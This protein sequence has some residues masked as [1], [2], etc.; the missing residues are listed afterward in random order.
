MAGNNTIAIAVRNTTAGPAG[1]IGRVHVVAAGG[2]ADLVTDG[3]W[4]A[5]QTAPAGWEQ[6]AFSDAGWPSSTDLGAYGVAPWATSVAAAPDPGTAASPLTVAAATVERRTNP[7][8]VDAAKPRFGWQLASAQLQQRQGAYQLTVGTTAGAA[9]VWDSGRV[10]SQQSVD[11]VYNGPGA[12]LACAATSG[13]YGSGTAQAAPGAWSAGQTFETALRNPA[14]EWVADFIGRRPTTDLSGASWIWYP[15]GDPA[16][17]VPPATRYFRRTFS[18]AAAPSSATLVVTG[19]D[20]AD[21]WVNGV[22]VSTSPRVT[23]SWKQA[24]TVDVTARLHAGTNTIAIAGQ[25]TTQSPAGDDRQAR[26]RRRDDARHRR[27]VEGEPDRPD[28]LGTAR[29]QRQR[30]GRRAGARRVRG[31]ALGHRCPGVHH[32]TRCCAR[33]S[34]S[35][36]RS[37]T[38]RLLST[39]LGLHETRLNGAKVGADALA[40]GWTDYTKRLQYK[41]YDVTGQMRQGDNVLGA[42]LGNGWYSGSVGFAGASATARSRGTRPSSCSRSRT[43]PRT[44]VQ[45]D[46]LVEGR[47]R[48]DPRRRPVPRRGRTTPGASCPA[49]TPPASTTPRGP[50]RS[51]GPRPS[52]TWWPRSTTA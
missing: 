36:S 23:D 11:V 51:S 41:E 18:L 4:K 10:A 39:A 19:D 28:R 15:E 26:R 7:L 49:G 38:A 24:A 27:R 29:L 42:Y 48:S 30:V 43:A 14:T 46:A 44:T 34:R 13:G 47:G 1:L 50:A 20:T 52:P 12:G 21:V 17:G 22:Q 16:A 9:D 8:G 45:T 2:T 37:A 32:G 40:P 33:R 3:S 5:A 25:N 31:G 35:P 6:P